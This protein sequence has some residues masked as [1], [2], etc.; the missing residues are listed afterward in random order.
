M[1]ST[2]KNICRFVVTLSLC[3]L[4]LGPQAC[5]GDKPRPE[6]PSAPTAGEKPATQPQAV[7]TETATMPATQPA[8]QTQPATKPATRPAGPVSTFSS[9]PPYPVQLYVSDPKEKQPGWLKVLALDEGKDLATVKGVFPQQNLIV[10][11]TEN[12]KRLE[13][14][15]GY[16]PMSQRK[17]VVLR[18][19]RQPM[20]INR[21][22]R[23]TVLE[24]RP[25]GEWIIEKPKK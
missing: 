7:A 14:H 2:I 20:D 5:S 23:Y 6:A 25:T 8:T 4:I 12:V 13:I 24:R 3:L 10:I 19:D 18:I 16:L 15:T 9:D 1:A 21:N 11:D 17:R 22:R